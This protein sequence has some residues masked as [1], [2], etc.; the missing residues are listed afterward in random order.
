MIKSMFWLIQKL[1]YMYKSYLFLKTIKILIEKG[2]NI[3]L[4]YNKI[5]MWVLIMK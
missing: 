3:I 1:K 4:I 2:H 5:E